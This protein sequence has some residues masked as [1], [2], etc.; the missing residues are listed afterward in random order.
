MWNCRV[1][2]LLTVAIA[3]FYRDSVNVLNDITNED[4]F[5]VSARELQSNKR[6]NISQ[7]CSIKLCLIFPT[8]FW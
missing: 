4:V 2:Q 8:S 5:H 3:F 6:A 7:N 1:K